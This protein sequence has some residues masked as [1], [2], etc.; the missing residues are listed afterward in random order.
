MRLVLD[1]QVTDELGKS[2]IGDVGLDRVLGVMVRAFC[3][4]YGTPTE[5]RL[6]V[7]DQQKGLYFVIVCE[8][9]VIHGPYAT[10]RERDNAIT[11]E[12]KDMDDNLPFVDLILLEIAPDGTANVRQDDLEDYLD[13]DEDEG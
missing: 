10:E 12:A 9:H 1:F 6:R 5:T 7:D 2:L 13:D 8:T 4:T 3:N 11:R